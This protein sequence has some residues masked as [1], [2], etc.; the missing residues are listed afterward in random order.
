MIDR[1]LRDAAHG[2]AHAA[3]A[4]A[5][6]LA[7]RLEGMLLVADL[8]DGGAAVDVDFPDLARTQ[9]HLG[10]ITFAREQLHGG[11]GRARE[12]RALAGKEFDAVYG[13][14][15]GDV[16]QRQRV[17]R[18][19]RRFRAR[20]QLRAR[21]YALRRDDVATLAVDITQQGEK[22]GA[23]RIVFQALDLCVDA[24]LVALEVDLAVMLLVAAALVAHRDLAVRVA[25]AALFLALDEMGYRAALVQFG[26]DHPHLLA[27]AGR[28]GFHL[29]QHYLASACSAKLISWPG[30]RLT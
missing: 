14:T 24:V 20:D 3:P 2:R 10:V 7:D 1:V 16:L 13:G 27:Q 12:L 5:P 8:A 4:H 11:A 21:G 6:R 26:I 29:D 28:H 19:D 22:G 23:V 30:L 17:A 9:R 18:L 15:H 25:A